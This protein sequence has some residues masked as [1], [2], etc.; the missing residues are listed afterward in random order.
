MVRG[1]TRNVYVNEW[2]RQTF[3]QELQGAAAGVLEANL[4]VKQLN[5]LA[6]SLR[7]GVLCSRLWLKWRVERLLQTVSSS[8]AIQQFYVNA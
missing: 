5:W 4:G 7:E 2:V 3:G 6:H 1:W 8:G